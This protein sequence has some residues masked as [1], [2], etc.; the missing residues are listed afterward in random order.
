MLGKAI[1]NS[2]ICLCMIAMTTKPL[3][4]KSNVRVKCDVPERIIKKT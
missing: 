2:C 3:I 1:R 4:N